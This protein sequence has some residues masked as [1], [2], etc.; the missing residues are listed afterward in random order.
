MRGITSSLLAVVAGLALAC[1]GYSSSSPAAP[2]SPQVPATGF[3]ITISNMSFSPLNLHVPAG[4][5]VTVVN[6]DVVEHSVTSEA[7][8]NSFTP[9]SVSGVSFD[10]GLF[11][12]THSFTIPANAPTG[13]VVPY[14]C[15]NHK[16][17]MN[18]PTGTITVDPSAAA[19]TTAVP[20]TPSMGGGG[21]Y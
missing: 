15:M 19:T 12:G 6:R 2:A 16:A 17:T 4:Q 21:G 3:L 13:A 9:G 7:S 5:T 14:Y 1:G 20:T 11:T 18:T 10:T 8:P